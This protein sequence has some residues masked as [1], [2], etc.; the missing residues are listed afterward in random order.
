MKTLL[1]A[2]ITGVSITAA[3]A[4]TI[5]QTGD[6]TSAST[7][8]QSGTGAISAQSGT[9]GGTSFA[10]FDP[11][12]GTLTGVTL[13]LSD[14][15]VTLTDSVLALFS[16]SASMAFSYHTLIEGLT[17]GSGNLSLGCSVSGCDVI[18]DGQVLGSGGTA[19]AGLDPSGFIGDGDLTWQAGT[20]ISG[21]TDCPGILCGFDGEIDASADY[22]V[23]YSYT[24]F[25]D[26]PEPA[27][28]ALLGLGCIGVAGVS[29]RGRSI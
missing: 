12:L 26:V 16:S 21:T 13:I 9:P 3:H 5:T 7:F 1:L 6:I 15:T 14:I 28:M 11:T 18:N 29:R 27:S 20:G 8:S 10:Q 19:F 24:P 22:S 25:A 4:A 23:V 2:A 17:V